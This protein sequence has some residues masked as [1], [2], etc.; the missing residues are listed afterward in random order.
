MTTTLATVIDVDDCG[1]EITSEWIRRCIDD[2]KE[3][4]D[5]FQLHFL[6]GIVFSGVRD[7]CSL[8]P[9]AHTF[10]AG[11]G[12]EWHCFLNN[13]QGNRPL[14]GP[15]VILNGTFYE[16]LRLYADTHAAF[17]TATR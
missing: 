5:V 12:M 11:L 7:G 1:S 16:P 14:P 2:Y 13:D 4:D 15:Y 9:D 8:S 6:H 17:F 3:T 10:L